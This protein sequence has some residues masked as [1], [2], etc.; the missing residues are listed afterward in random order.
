MGAYNGGGTTLR[1]AT[2]LALA[3]ATSTTRAM[4]DTATAGTKEMVG[5]ANNSSRVATSADSNKSALAKVLLPAAG[6]HHQ[7]HPANDMY[8]R[9]TCN[10]ML[11]LDVE[12]MSK[13][14]A[15]P[16]AA[17]AR[18]AA[19]ACASAPAPAE[20]CAPASA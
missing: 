10:S 3:A 5:T 2:T 6:G 14:P 17:S 16:V 18:S 12:N 15:L 13:F 7:R 1:G 19:L 4:V 8:Y 11:V 20:V 9:E